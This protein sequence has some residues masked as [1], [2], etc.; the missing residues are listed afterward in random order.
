[1]EVVSFQGEASLNVALLNFHARRTD[2]DSVKKIQKN[3]LGFKAS[4]PIIGSTLVSTNV[5]HHPKLL[6]R[7]K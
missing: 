2:F 6:Q 1:M 5:L 7:K 3:D 4:A